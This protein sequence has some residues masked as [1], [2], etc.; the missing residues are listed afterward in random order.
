MYSTDDILFICRRFIWLIK[1]F[2]WISQMSLLLMIM[3]NLFTNIC[4]YYDIQ[5]YQQMYADWTFLQRF[6]TMLA[7]R[8][9]QG[10]RT[11]WL[12]YSAFFALKFA[13]V[14]WSPIRGSYAFNSFRIILI[15]TYLFNC[16]SCIRE[17]IGS[18]LF[19]SV[20]TRSS[21][22]KVALWFTFIMYKYFILCKRFMCVFFTSN[23]PV[24]IIGL[25]I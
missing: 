2:F 18:L 24:F 4:S 5:W 3:I 21:F 20:P 23:I 8:F 25:Q 11:D 10:Q 22:K 6:P 12:D 7:L 15:H 13:Y 17:H 19:H 14:M 9:P 1:V 16:N